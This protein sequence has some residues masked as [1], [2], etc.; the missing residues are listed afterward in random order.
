MSSHYDPIRPF[1][2]QYKS[3]FCTFDTSP[4]N[5]QNAIHNIELSLEPILNN[6]DD[7]EDVYDLSTRSHPDICMFPEAYIPELPDKPKHV[8]DDPK[9]SHDQGFFDTFPRIFADETPKPRPQP[10]IPTCSSN[11]TLYDD[12]P[13]SVPLVTHPGIDK[14]LMV[15]GIT[16]E[17]RVVGK[18]AIEQM[19]RDAEKARE[20][21]LALRPKIWVESLDNIEK[22]MSN[23]LRTKFF[24]DIQEELD[25]IFIRCLNL[26][27]YYTVMGEMMSYYIQLW[28][29]YQDTVRVLPDP[30]YFEGSD[31]YDNAEAQAKFAFEMYIMFYLELRHFNQFVE[32]VF[33]EKPFKLSRFVLTINE[34]TKTFITTLKQLTYIFC[35]YI[36]KPY[37][38]K[39]EI[40]TPFSSVSKIKQSP[41]TISTL[42]SYLTRNIDLNIYQPFINELEEIDLLSRYKPYILYRYFK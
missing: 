34:K 16:T 31:A 30:T 35:Y 17:G 26:K 41:T 13:I 7:D 29:L 42:L 1:L 2:S 6:A 11:S 10:Q 22:E 18:D 20:A 25:N 3:T 36:S 4:D 27:Q 15:F 8:K 23:I 9:P 19:Y 33:L 12:E 39:K 24:I 38:I 28:L 21:V 14:S 5:I 37:N 32:D 40:L